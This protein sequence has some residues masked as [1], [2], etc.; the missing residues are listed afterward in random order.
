[1]DVHGGTYQTFAALSP[2]PPP[3]PPVYVADNET[4]FV[5]SCVVLLLYRGSVGVFVQ[6]QRAQHLYNI[7][8]AAAAA[9]S[10][11]FSLLAYNIQTASTPIS[12]PLLFRPHCSVSCI[13]GRYYKT[14]RFLFFFFFLFP[15]SSMACSIHSAFPPGSV[16]KSRRITR[17]AAQRLYTGSPQYYST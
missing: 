2:P 13:H 14:R 12:S 4:G 9:L 1:M 16:E 10:Q 6:Q 7:T 15:P 8:A 3:P 11:R 17:S 5:S